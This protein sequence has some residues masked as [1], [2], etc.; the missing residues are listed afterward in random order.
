M[1]SHLFYFPFLWLLLS[2]LEC[3]NHFLLNLIH[4]MSRSSQNNFDFLTLF[5]ISICSNNFHIPENLNIKILSHWLQCCSL[6]LLYCSWYSLSPFSGILKKILLYYIRFFIS[7]LLKS[8]SVI[9]PDFCPFIVHLPSSQFLIQQFSVFL[10]QQNNFS[11]A[12]SFPF[13]DL[14]F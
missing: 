8:K 9:L 13:T 4:N 6:S 11:F 10:L 12:P 2:F 7:T 5:K 14:F 1:Q 3:I